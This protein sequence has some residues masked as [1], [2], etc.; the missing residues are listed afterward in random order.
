M[1]KNLKKTILICLFIVGMVSLC[2]CASKK[3]IV[4]KTIKEVEENIG[5]ADHIF[6]NENF[7]VLS[8]P[9]GNE[10]ELDALLKKS[11]TDYFSQVGNEAEEF[12]LYGA[13]RE[14][15]FDVRN[16]SNV[17]QNFPIE[18]IR[19]GK[20]FNGKE[21]FY[22]P[23]KVDEGGI[24]Y[25]FWS[26]SQFFEQKDRESFLK[27]NHVAEYTLYLPEKDLKM[28]DFFS[29]DI[30]TWADVEK[31]DANS[32]A[33]LTWKDGIS[34]FNTM[35][36]LCDGTN[37][38]I[39]YHSTGDA[40]KKENYEI[41][42]FGILE[43]DLSSA[44]LLKDLPNKTEIN[45]GDTPLAVSA[46]MSA[47]EIVR[48]TH[49]KEKDFGLIARAYTDGIFAEN[50]MVYLFD[51]LKTGRICGISVYR[52]GELLSFEGNGSVVQAAD[53]NGIEGKTTTEAFKKID[54]EKSFLSERV[55]SVNGFEIVNCWYFLADNGSIY[56]VVEKGNE[57]IR[58]YLHAM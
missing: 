25:V 27:T 8:L 35:H 24:F 29:S 54:K 48:E 20:N 43:H 26:E 36:T 58:C 44:I 31:L 40:S 2:A 21:V 15:A 41:S 6:S 55:E 12:A 32:N 9:C 47:W 30:K 22:T 34:F 14:D 16:I 49:S 11:Y 10:K 39:C 53:F 23:Y 52:D 33:F 57:I 13:F 42:S 28:E 17:H 38:S 3:T 56:E 7:Y 51:P 19:C 5:S 18:Y 4:E 37:L 46:R 50:K 45:I 1:K